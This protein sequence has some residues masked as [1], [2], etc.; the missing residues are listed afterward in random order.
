MLRARLL[1]AA[2]QQRPDGVIIV[3]VG[4]CARAFNSLDPWA[5]QPATTTGGCPTGRHVEGAVC[6]DAYAGFRRGPQ[7]T[8]LLATPAPRLVPTLPTRTG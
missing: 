1:R 5:P 3:S 6:G 7:E 2:A 8:G 4:A